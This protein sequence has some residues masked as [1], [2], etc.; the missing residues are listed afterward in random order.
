M[1]WILIGVII[2]LAQKGNYANIYGMANPVP[3]TGKYN[4]I[5][6]KLFKK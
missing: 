2:S 1:N 3:I 6:I 4:H 5:L